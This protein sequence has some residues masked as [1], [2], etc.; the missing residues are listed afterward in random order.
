[1]P[2]FS[3]NYLPFRAQHIILRCIQRH[4]ETRFFQ[5]I[6]RWLPSE[7]IKVG[8]KCAESVELHRVFNFLAKYQGNI[9]DSRFNLAWKAIQRWRCV[10]TNIRHAAVHRIEQGRDT[11]LRMNHIAIKLVRCIAGFE[12]SHSLRGLQ[13]VLHKKISS[14]DQ[15]NSQLWRNLDRQLLLCD[16]CPKDHEKRLKLLPEAANR[17]QQSHEDKFLAEVS[18]YIGTEFDSS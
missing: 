4:L 2:G 10:I 3:S 14:L 15:L 9:Q 18:N 1:M 6:V 17:L 16:T 7:S 8:W 13:K 11:L 5:F 12:M